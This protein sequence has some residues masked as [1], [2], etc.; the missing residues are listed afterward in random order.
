MQ[1]INFPDT[2]LKKENGVNP[3]RSYQHIA[4]IGYG[5][6]FFEIKGDIDVA[7]KWITWLWKEN[8]SSEG[9]FDYHNFFSPIYKCHYTH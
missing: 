5:L 3:T 8:D 4:N 9:T 2:K 1:S 6:D 7:Y